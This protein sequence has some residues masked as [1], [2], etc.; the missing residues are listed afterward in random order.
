MLN[1][2][3]LSI[4]T[5]QLNYI[6]FHR[7]PHSI[8]VPMPTLPETHHLST[9]D[10]RPIPKGWSPPWTW[11]SRLQEAPTAQPPPITEKSIC[12]GCGDKKPDD[13]PAATGTKPPQPEIGSSKEV[14][15][16]DGRIKHV[17]LSLPLS[18]SL[19]LPPQQLLQY[20]PDSPLKQLSILP[21]NVTP[22]YIS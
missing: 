22:P 2:L 17:T 19:I 4:N 16:T 12:A 6:S 1:N 10:M 5:S 21:V 20:T 11:E 14:G 3:W 8:L 9:G 18:P 7:E 15:A 13:R